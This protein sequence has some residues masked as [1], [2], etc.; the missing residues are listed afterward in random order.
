VEDPARAEIPAERPVEDDERVAVLTYARLRP[1][2]APQFFRASAAAERRAALDPSMV[3]GTAM[4]APP[5]TFATFSLWR[6]AAE[7]RRYAYTP[8]EH[9]DAMR[10]MRRYDFHSEY[11]FARF[12]PYGEEGVWE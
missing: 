4:A 8:G 5:R 10:A 7:M 11:L 9:T 6:T 1:R 2:R 12:R 3:R